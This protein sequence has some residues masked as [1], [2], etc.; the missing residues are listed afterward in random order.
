[1][2]TV[3]IDSFGG[4]Q[5]RVHPSLLRDGMAITAHNVKLKSGKLVPLRQPSGV[6]GVKTDIENGLRDLSEAKSLHV[7]RQ[8]DGSF[9]F[10]AFPGMTWMS[11]GNIADDSESRVVVSGDTGRIFTDIDD[12]EWRDSPQIFLEEDGSRVVHSLC[13]NPLEKPNVERVG[14]KLPSETTIVNRGYRT[15]SVINSWSLDTSDKGTIAVTSD[16]GT[17][18]EGDLGVVAGT[19]V[20]WDGEK[21]MLYSEVST[22]ATVRY[23]F[24]FWTWVD[25]YGYESPVSEASDEVVYNDGDTVSFLAPDK[26]PDEAEK[27]RFYKVVT[28]SEEGRIQFV[29]EQGREDFGRGASFAVKDE[30]AGE[31]IAEIESPMPDTRCILDVPGGYYC[32]FSP[33][34]PKTVCFSEVGLL[35]SWPVAYRYDVKDSIVALAV[36]SNTVF[37]LTDGFPYVLNGT[38]PGGMTVTKIAGPAACVSERGVCVYK[39]AVYFAGNAGL[40]AIYNNSDAG[41]VCEN[42]TDKIF[43]KDQWTAL[44][45]SSCL[46]GQFDG[47][48]YL[49]FELPDGTHKGIVVDLTETSAAVTTHDEWARCLCVDVAKDRMYFVRDT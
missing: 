23:T 8:N 14:G 37:A 40:M 41:T 29:Y 32:G 5:P 44:N 42:L 39:N 11:R 38:N 2:A 22:G 36:T 21:W 28:G 20:Y 30:D 1:M 13:K 16:A 48:L 25:K 45:P 43:T 4:I 15:T 12:V 46:M 6:S 3:K 19:S 49:F 34:M 10:V 33:S 9:R 17:L 7:W 31:V 47:A 24:F 18:T 27:I 26:V 35:Y